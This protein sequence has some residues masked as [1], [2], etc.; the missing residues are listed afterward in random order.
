MTTPKIESDPLKVR[1]ICDEVRAQGKKVSFVPTMGA[2]HE[3][4]LTL[5]DE[6]A[7]FA[8]FTVVSIFVNPT[9]FGPGEDFSSY[10]RN[11]DEDAGKLAPRGVDLIFAPE[12]EDMYP[13]GS[14]TKVIQTGLTEG[15]CGASR[16][17]HFDGVTTVVTKLFNI[18]G[19]CTAVFGRKDYQQLA[20]IKQ[21]VKDLNM[22]IQVR[23][24]ATVRESDNVAMSSR[25]AYLSKEERVR[26]R[27][28]SKG[29]MA[30]HELFKKGERKVGVLKNAV[31]KLVEPASDQLDYIIAAH[32]DTL[33]LLDDR[34][35]ADEKMLI[36][37]AI[38]IGATRLIDNTV[39]GEDIF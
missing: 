13:S 24:I 3:G 22:P 23:G 7:A 30:A 4:H 26:A 32:P 14:V 27:V 31:K 19:P 8:D 29:L 20:V 35:N 15:L 21:M 6:A 16:P 28:L 5:A 38:K 34:Q 9:Q 17:G 1:A 12:V 39:L 18:V 25:N 10:P 11:L 36:A 33:D 37:I 2:L